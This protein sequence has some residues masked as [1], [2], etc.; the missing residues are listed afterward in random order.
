[1]KYGDYLEHLLKDPNSADGELFNRATQELLNLEQE[2][3]EVDSQKEEMEQ[4]YRHHV[5]LLHPEIF[6]HF[7]RRYVLEEKMT[8]AEQAAARAE[9]FKALASCLHF[10]LRESDW[11]QVG[12]DGLY[13]AHRT[14]GYHM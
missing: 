14:F 8:V 13:K 3:I 5:P 10:D 6:Y 9:E 11:N 4:R 7:G 1:M 2:A 12:S